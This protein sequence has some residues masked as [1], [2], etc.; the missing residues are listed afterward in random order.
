MTS[1]RRHSSRSPS[2]RPLRDRALY[3]SIS[4][5]LLL[6]LTVASGLLVYLVSPLRDPAFQTDSANAGSLIPLVRQVQERYWIWGAAGL[7]GLLATNLVLLLWQLGQPLRTVLIAV[8]EQRGIAAVW[9][10]ALIGLVGVYVVLGLVLFAGLWVVFI[11]YL[12]GQWLVD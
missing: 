9:W 1:N 5:G 12:V 11:G 3:P 6:L 7:A 2:N 8:Q 10:G 4:L